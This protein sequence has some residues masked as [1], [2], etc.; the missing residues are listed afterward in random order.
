MVD[1]LQNITLSFSCDAGDDFVVDNFSGTEQLSKLFHYKLEFHTDS[2]V[3]Q[4]DPTKL[5]GTSIYVTLLLADGETKRS[6]NGYVKSLTTFCQDEQTADKQF[7]YY[8]LEI[9]PWLWFLT[10]G[11]NSRVYQGVSIIDVVNS[12]INSYG[13]SSQCSSTI[14]GSYPN[15][16]LPYIIQYNET[17]YD[18]VARLL[19]QAGVLYYF[20]H[21]DNQNILV[22]GDAISVYRENSY[23]SGENRV[24]QYNLIDSSSSHLPHISHWCH[25]YD[26]FPGAYK[27]ND[28]NFESSALNLELDPAVEPAPSSLFPS[29]EQAKNI[30]V[31][32]Y[33]GGYGNTSDGSTISKIRAD[34]LA[35]DY[36]S[37]TGVENY[38]AFTPGT[39]FEI[40]SEITFKGESITKYVITA[41]NL[42]IGQGQDYSCNFSSVPASVIYYP[43]RIPAPVCDR[44]HNANVVETSAPSEEGIDE[45]ADEGDE[46]AEEEAKYYTD[47][48]GRLS[49]QTRWSVNPFWVR[50]PYDGVN[51]TV[52]RVGVPVVIDLG[53]PLD[54][55]NPMLVG[56]VD[57]DVQTPP[58]PLD[59]SENMSITSIWAR[60]PSKSPTD[61]ELAYNRI[62]INDDCA[63][64]NNQAME[65]YAALGLSAVVNNVEEVSPEDG[66][67]DLNIW[68]KPKSNFEHKIDEGN[69]TFTS[70]KGNGDFTFTEGDVTRTFSDGNLTETVTAGTY[71]L[72]VGEN[73]TM[74]VNQ[75]GECTIN[76]ASLSIE[77]EK[78]VSIKAGTELSQEAG[79]SFSNES[80]T[81]YS[82]NAGT[83]LD[84]QAK[85]TAT[86]KGLN[87]E[88]DASTSATHS[89]GASMSVGGVTTNLGK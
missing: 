70:T 84:M 68:Q 56:V 17:D 42:Q 61:A 65:F 62:V 55:P 74:T 82:I 38:G 14:E 72:N 23:I 39:T 53:G 30:T 81:D 43:E 58:Y 4:L 16:T 6:I 50:V 36:H 34:M 80:G 69:V 49:V 44:L 66:A 9:V 31:E 77:T 27:A 33:P 88:T 8:S 41:I 22:M 60:P 48:F 5:I 18:F 52:V 57:D 46:G 54:K 21:V 13:F 35:K 10:Q 47:K 19:A 86:L 76:A 75:E 78:G 15:Q 51:R 12:V 11:M 85:T 73:F 2:S 29:L 40:D 32:E 89:A 64:G 20:S 63:A 87:V 28:F 7:K 37:V 1:N 71:T 79:T 45:G 25:V 83:G 26:L 3:S 67:A 59:E 24:V